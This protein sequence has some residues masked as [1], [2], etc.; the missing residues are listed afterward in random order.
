MQDIL[1]QP[2][3]YKAIQQ[4]TGRQLYANIWMESM[5]M[6]DLIFL[7]SN[8]IYLVEFVFPYEG[9]LPISNAAMPSGTLILVG[10]SLVNEKAYR[11]SFCEDPFLCAIISSDSNDSVDTCRH[12]IRMF[13]QPTYVRFPL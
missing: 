9:I 13:F 12:K 11:L 3:Q 10:L 7:Q 2:R 6:E 4:Y 5:I 1:W 8:V